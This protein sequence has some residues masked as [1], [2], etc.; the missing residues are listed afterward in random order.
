MQK[1]GKTLKHGRIFPIFYNF[2]V[3]I[4]ETMRYFEINFTISAPESIYN[5][6]CDV[7]AAM[8]GETGFETFEEAEGGMK[9]YVQQELFC[10]QEL[11]D[12]LGT[13]PFT[14][15]SV[16]YQVKE[17]ED[18]D[19][20]EE[21]EKEGFEP[22]SIG[23]DLVI[24]DGRHL[25][26]STEAQTLVEIDARLAFG[27]GNHETTRMMVETLMERPLEGKSILDC[28]TGTGVLAIVA[29]L[30]GATEAVG[31]DIDEWSVEN[32]RHNALLNGVEQRFTAF[33][34]DSFVI[35]QQQ[36]QFDVVLANI[37]RNI[38][39]A[40]MPRM[41]H[42]LKPGGALL[43]SGFYVGDCQL[44]EEKAA[45]LGLVRKQIKREGEWACIEFELKD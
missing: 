32:A 26:H 38:L 22:I 3:K 21:W 1:Y 28:G 42:A 4:N 30:R 9:G 25:P 44:I 11:D 17:A 27:T 6:V 36:R 29:L 13:L 31:Y 40:D 2:A 19:W 43:L 14:D 35:E 23:N 7:L 5:D 24:Y 15:V 16:S 39:L 45:T 8:A 34:G 12:I 33:L 41:C 10:R 37:N 20:N 18:R